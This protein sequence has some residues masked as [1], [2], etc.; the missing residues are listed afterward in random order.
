[1]RTNP[2]IYLFTICVPDSG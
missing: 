1:V 2:E